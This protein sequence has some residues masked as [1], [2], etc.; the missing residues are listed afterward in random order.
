MLASGKLIP[1]PESSLFDC[2]LGLEFAGRRAD[3]GDRVMGMVPFKGIATTVL[4]H[5]DFL[6]T[7]PA[8]WSL[9][10][11][12]SVPVIYIT[13]YYALVMR[14][15]LKKGDTVLIHSGAGG[16]G[17]AAIN[18]CKHMG[19]TIFTSVGTDAKR[20]FLRNKFGLDDQHICNSRDV[21]FER[22]VKSGTKGRG[23][24]VVL[25]SLTGDKLLASFRCLA[26]NGRFLEIGKYDMQMNTA[27]GMFPFLNN[28]TFHGVGLDCFFRE[29][30]HSNQLAEF[31]G[32]V[33]ELIAKGIEDGVVRPIERTVF[34]RDSVERAFRYMTNGQHIG[35]VLIEIRPE[36]KPQL[37]KILEPQPVKLNALARTWFHPAKVYLVAGG[38]GGVGLEL[39]YWMV[40]RGARKLI[41][42]SRSGLKSSY[43]KVF[44]ERFRIIEQFCPDYKITFKISIK[45]IGNKKECAQ[46]LDEVHALG[47]I[48]GIFNLTLVL[49]DGLFE[50]QTPK[51]FEAVCGP[52]LNGLENL[53]QL[54]REK[55]K[56]F[57]SL[58][59]FV[60]FSSFSAGRGNAG[61][62]NYGY[63]NSAMERIVER[64]IEASLPGLAVQFGPINDVGIVAE[65]VFASEEDGGA[66]AD[67][68]SMKLLM[69]LSM[70]RLNSCLE[71]LD[72][73][74]P[75]RCGVFSS[76]ICYTNNSDKGGTDDEV[77]R[78]L[79]I[80]L[81]IDKRPEDECLGDIGL[82]SMAAVE[83]QQ[84]LERDF[85]ISLTLADVR[86][87]TVK[88]LKNFRDGN[89]HNLK[90]Y[91]DDIKKAKAN[92][93]R[94]R[95]VI[96]TTELSAL[97]T[98][99]ERK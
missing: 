37:E 40:L 51:K 55:P 99:Q 1:G 52:K 88:E 36:E 80:H 94:I 60:A 90:Q 21:S 35:K 45:N 25:N 81:N 86:K 69:G 22:Q 43:Q 97:N 95:F 44:L 61:Q 8:Q 76:Y 19:C 5:R 47:T 28:I 93:S 49:E 64:R 14:G 58:D 84:R 4:T 20:V 87:I 72:Q 46:L 62:T 39:I 9:E 67:E 10:E 6:W 3:T 26:V 27:L 16:V 77:I 11:A 24:D 18:I 23:V 66:G 29:G 34:P 91:S 31:I 75:R 78:Q 13:A 12:A 63:A 32:E 74:L 33:S 17:Q 50:N 68:N 71:V 57:E 73:L 70:Q 7:V 41:L 85:N 30:F 79:C 54:T 92:L 38:L 56:M 2:I 48:G 65:H 98:I 15:R 96:P 82:D 83:I 53:D 89:R 42:T 59:H